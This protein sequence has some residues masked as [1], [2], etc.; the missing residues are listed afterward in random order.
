MLDISHLSSPDP[1]HIDTHKLLENPTPREVFAKKNKKMFRL[2][3]PR[4][5]QKQVFAETPCKILYRKTK[6]TFR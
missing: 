2:S 1:A 5:N 4:S 6:T 3:Q